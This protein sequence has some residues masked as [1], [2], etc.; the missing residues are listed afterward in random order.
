MAFVMV[1]TGLIFQVT[2]EYAVVTEAMD[3][4]DLME[5]HVSTSETTFRVSAVIG[6]SADAEGL[7]PFYIPPEM[8][9]GVVE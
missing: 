4:K 3:G 7:Q 1:S 6:A 9:A 2:E 8:P 5:L